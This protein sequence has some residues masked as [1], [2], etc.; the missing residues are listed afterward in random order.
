MQTKT[1]IVDAINRLTAL[2][3]FNSYF[4]DFFFFLEILPKNIPFFFYKCVN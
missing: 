2:K 3:L 4:I 1:F